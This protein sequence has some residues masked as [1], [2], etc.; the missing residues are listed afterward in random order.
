[1]AASSSTFT[2]IPLS[3]AR[4]RTRLANSGAVNFPPGS[5]TRSRASDTPSTTA[6]PRPTAD[7][8]PAAVLPTSETRSIPRSAFLDV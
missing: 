3:R 6:S 4:R 8:T 1:M 5:F 7:R 2:V